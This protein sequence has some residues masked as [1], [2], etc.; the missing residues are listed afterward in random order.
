MNT[1][2]Y[3]SLETLDPIL[4]VDFPAPDGPLA[5]RHLFRK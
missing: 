1:P 5:K 4:D 3:L 2:S